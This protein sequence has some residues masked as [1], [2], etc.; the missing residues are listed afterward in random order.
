ME[1]LVIE[2][3][4]GIVRGITAVLSDAWAIR[5]KKKVLRTMLTHSRYKWRTISTLSRSIRESRDVTEE[6]LLQMGARPDESGKPIW[7]LAPRA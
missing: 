1:E 2:I 5:L 4:S 6:M 3:V 7:T